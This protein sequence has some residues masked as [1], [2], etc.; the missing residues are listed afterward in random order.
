MVTLGPLPIAQ[1]HHWLVRR[2]QANP[3]RDLRGIVIHTT[4][5]KARDRGAEDLLNRQAT[6]RMGMAGW[7][8][9]IDQEGNITECTPPHLQA[10]HCA[11]NHVPLYRKPNWRAQK[12]TQNVKASP[13]YTWWLERHLGYESPLDRHPSLVYRPGSINQHTLGVELLSGQEPLTEPAI[14]ALT[15]ICKVAHPGLIVTTHSDCQPL[16]RNNYDLNDAQRDQILNL[17]T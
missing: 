13:D 15:F 1:S 12:P 7:H 8:Y 5:A 2:G 14:H 10:N 16:R 4:G 9:L 17:L 11:T 3:L 6:G